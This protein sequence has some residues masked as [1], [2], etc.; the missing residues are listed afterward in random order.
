MADFTNEELATI[1]HV[2]RRD[3]KSAGVQDIPYSRTQV[4]SAFNAI[5]AVLDGA[6]FRTAINDAITTAIAPETMS[7]AEK[8]GVFKR[9]LEQYLKGVA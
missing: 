3:L 9:V 2:L 1:T 5:K 7:A 6:A 4:W 8:N